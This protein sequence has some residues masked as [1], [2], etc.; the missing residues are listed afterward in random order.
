M[1][2]K[3]DYRREKWLRETEDNATRM[4]PELAGRIDWDTAI[5]LYN[6]GLG[7]V[8]AAAFEIL[9][10]PRRTGAHLR[11]R[12]LRIVRRVRAGDVAMTRR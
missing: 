1:K 12:R 5:H 7:P 6:Q 2:V 4:K 8:E 3:R 10:S 11:E 9:H